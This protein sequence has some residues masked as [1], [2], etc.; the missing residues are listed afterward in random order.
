MQD[1]MQQMTKER[2]ADQKTIKELREENNKLTAKNKDVWNDC[3]SI[4]GGAAVETRSLGEE[5]RVLIQTL[6]DEG[7]GNETKILK[8][9]EDNRKLQKELENSDKQNTEAIK[10]NPS[11][12]SQLDVTDVFKRM[13]EDHT[14]ELEKKLW[15]PMHGGSTRSP[16]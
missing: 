7:L 1:E 5:N 14:L 8:Q 13:C 12:L 6:K 16:W 2:E 4:V 9:R 3:L 10:V 11:L 15:K